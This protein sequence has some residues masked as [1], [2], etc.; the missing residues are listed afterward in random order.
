M[1]LS[2]VEEWRDIPQVDG[3]YEVSDFGRVRRK[4]RTEQRKDGKQYHAKA[5]IME[6]VYT[7]PQH[8]HIVVQLKAPDKPRKAIGIKRLVYET[9]VGP[10]PRGAVIK[11]RNGEESDIRPDNL[12]IQG[13]A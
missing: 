1:T 11:C 12:F 13:E 5:K 7:G 10:V 8:S 6:R 9:F 3:L 4:A 2:L